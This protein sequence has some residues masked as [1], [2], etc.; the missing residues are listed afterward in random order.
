[1]TRVDEGL[2]DQLKRWRLLGGRWHVVHLSDQRAVV[3][4]CTCT[5]EPLERLESDDPRLI[6]YLRLTKS[7]LDPN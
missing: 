2:I 6:A 1:M 7:D 3:E 5:G 4:M